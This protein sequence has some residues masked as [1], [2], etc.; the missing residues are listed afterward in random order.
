M[1]LNK[2]NTTSLIQ[3]PN[4][5]KAICKI[6]I[7]KIEDKDLIKLSL[8]IVSDAITAISWHSDLNIMSNEKKAFVDTFVDFGIC[9]L[10]INIIE[11]YPITENDGY[12]VIQLACYIIADITS[13]RSFGKNSHEYMLKF[14]AEG[15]VNCLVKLYN[16]PFYKSY[17][18]RTVREVVKSLCA[19]D[20]NVIEQFDVLG[21]SWDSNFFLEAA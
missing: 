13:F 15:I 21:I 17:L 4:I 5:P 11:I 7:E 20:M 1:I 10:L 3:A 12:D 2:E 8:G 6:L 18:R 16:S 9:E 14:I 19:F